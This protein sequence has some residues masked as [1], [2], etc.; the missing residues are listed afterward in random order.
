[1][2]GSCGTTPIA[3][4]S[5]GRPVAATILAT[6][7]AEPEYFEYSRYRLAGAPA[8]AT[9]QHYVAAV[10]QVSAADA[11]TV[12]VPGADGK[13][14]PVAAFGLLDGSAAT[15]DSSLASLRIL[16]G[17]VERVVPTDKITPDC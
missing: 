10:A 2:K 1:M 9:W 8:A 4:L 15:S 14:R 11:G 16:I 13:A 12:L 17:P 6:N 3:V 7:A 5:A